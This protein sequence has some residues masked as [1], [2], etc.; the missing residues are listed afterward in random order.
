[1]A[2]FEASGT[3]EMTLA[4]MKLSRAVRLAAEALTELVRRQVTA[5]VGVA[6]IGW[7]RPAPARPVPVPLVVVQDALAEVTQRV[8]LP[9]H[10]APIWR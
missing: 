9:S 7:G 2:R 6:A 3:E 8:F 5:T 4:R 10:V 1:M